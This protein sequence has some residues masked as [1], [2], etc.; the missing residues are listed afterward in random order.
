MYTRLLLRVRKQFD[1]GARQLF[2]TL[3]IKI[4]EVV[5][6]GSAVRQ[7][8][9][10]RSRQLSNSGDSDIDSR[11]SEARLWEEIK[12]QSFTTL[13]VTAYMLS[14]VCV[15]MRI[16]LYILARSAKN[17]S[18][19]NSSDAD[20][21]GGSSGVGIS[22]PSS[23]GAARKGAPNLSSEED[24]NANAAAMDTDMFRDLV[25]GTFQQ[26]F[27]TGLRSFSSIVKR[28]MIADLSEWSVKDK[29]HVEYSELFSLMNTIRTNLESDL[30]SMIRLIALPPEA[31]PE[32]ETLPSKNS[33][34]DNAAVQLLLAQIWDVI[35]SPLFLVAFSEAIDTSFKHIF[36][37]L[38]KHVFSPDSNSGSSEFYQE[39][40]PPLASLLPQL[41]AISARL[42][43]ADPDTISYE[44][45]DVS[46]GIALDNLCLAVFDAES[47]AP[48]AGSNSNST[49]GDILNSFMKGSASRQAKRPTGLDLWDFN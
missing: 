42:L 20:S 25:E 15:L 35:D 38:Q 43:P 18:A 6:V 33:R 32:A 11:E 34:R 7:I 44:V 23:R 14:A 4:N 27:G 37:C 45:K 48:A 40:S 22:T 46:N 8:K 21:F 12:I 5:D 1:V 29:L 49:A 36:D 9:E 30:H 41:K 16:Q 13:Y 26:I 31:A 24:L 39:R 3:R 10:L 19:E 17:N 47:S 28:Q 2:P